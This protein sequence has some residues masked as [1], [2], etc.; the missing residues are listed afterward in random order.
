MN[1]YIHQLT[2]S[3]TGLTTDLWI[4]STDQIQPQESHQF[5]LGFVKDIEDHPFSIS[6]ETYYKKM[7]HIIAYKQG[8][9]FIDI[10]N[11]ETAQD[12]DWQNNITFGQG[13]AYGAEFLFRKQRGSLTGWMGYTLSWSERQFDE[14]NFGNKFYA[15]YDRR[16]DLSLVGIYKPTKKVT[17]SCSWVFSSGINYTLPT[18]EG[19]T[20]ENE[21]PIRPGDLFLNSNIV[22]FATQVNNFRGASTHRLDVSVQFH[23]ARKKN[24]LRTWGISIYNAYARKNPFFYSV[25]NNIGF[26]SG[27]I[28]DER[29]LKKTFNFG[30]CTFN[31]V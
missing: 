25:T 7:N 10:Q 14:L 2:N 24:Q 17:Y 22:P 28:T 5:A 1:Q 18:Y 23:K 31:N 3:G 15:R 20:V 19:L 13:W 26:A 11:L 30:F 6:L 27:T 4:S 9:S 16:H 29:T 8:A 12:I 21:F